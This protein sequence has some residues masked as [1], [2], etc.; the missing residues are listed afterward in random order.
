MLAESGI[1]AFANAAYGYFASPFA[2]KLGASTLQMG[3]FSA[4][5][6]LLT[7]LDMWSAYLVSPLGGRKRMVVTTVVASAVPWLFMA[8][9]PFIPEPLRVWFLIPLAHV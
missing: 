9:I 6:E 3:L 5:T 1:M 8:F 4:I 7:A 2:I